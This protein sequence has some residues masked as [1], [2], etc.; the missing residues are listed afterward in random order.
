MYHSHHQNLYSS[1]AAH[2]HYLPIPPPPVPPT[3]SSSTDPGIPPPPPKGCG[4]SSRVSRTAEPR[5]MM[6]DTSSTFQPLPPVSTLTPQN[7]V[8]RAM[9]K[10]R[11]RVAN[12]YQLPPP[13]PPPR[14]LP[15]GGAPSHFNP[16]EILDTAHQ[17]TVNS[18][19]R[20]EYRR[21]PIPL[22]SIPPPPVAP[23]LLPPPPTPP[24]LAP[25]PPPPPLLSAFSEAGPSG[26]SSA[27]SSDDEPPSSST[28]KKRRSVES[29]ARRKTKKEQSRRQREREDEEMALRQDFDD[30][31][32]EEAKM[33]IGPRT[34]SEPYPEERRPSL[35]LSSFP[36]RGPRTPPEPY[37]GGPRTP[38]PDD[39]CEA[40]LN[41]NVNGNGKLTARP[42]S[43]ARTPKT[44]N[45]KPV[46][47]SQSPAT[48]EAARFQSRPLP[49]AFFGM[50]SAQKALKTSVS[51]V[52]EQPAQKVEKVAAPALESSIS[53]PLVT[54]PV[55]APAPV[56]TPTLAPTLPKPVPKLAE[57]ATIKSPAPAAATTNG[58]TL[59][60]GELSLAKRMEAFR[61]RRAAQESANDAPPNDTNAISEK[62]KPSSEVVEPEEA[63]AP[64][65]VPEPAAPQP[66]KEPVEE[67]VEDSKVEGEEEEEEK[68]EKIA[69]VTKAAV[70][71]HPPQQ[72]PAKRGRKR[73]APPPKSPSPSPSATADADATKMP[74]PS[75]CVSTYRTFAEE[76]T[77]GMAMESSSKRRKQL[78]TSS[79]MCDSIEQRLM[80]LN[81][82]MQEIPSRMPD[83]PSPE[84]A[85][86]K[87]ERAIAQSGLISSGRSSSTSSL[88]PS[89]SG[90][91]QA[92]P[93]RALSKSNGNASCSSLDTPNT[94]E[95]S[96]VEIIEETSAKK[97]T[98]T[99]HQYE[100]VASTEPKNT[101]MSEEDIARTDRYI[102][103][104][105]TIRKQREAEAEAA[106]LRSRSGSSVKSTS[107]PF[108]RS[109]DPLKPLSRSEREQ[110]EMVDMEEEEDRKEVVV[111]A[112]VLLQ[113]QQQTKRNFNVTSSASSSSSSAPSRLRAG[114]TVSSII[115]ASP[116]ES[117]KTAMAQL[118]KMPHA[119]ERSSILAKLA[120]R[121][122]ENGAST[123]KLV[124]G[125]IK[126][127]EEEEEDRKARR[128]NRRI[129]PDFEKS[130]RDAERAALNGELY[131]HSI[132]ARNL[133]ELTKLYNLPRI[134]NR[135][136]KFLR[137]RNHPNGGATMLSCDFNRLKNYLKGD[138][139]TMFCRQFVR[140]GFAER[141][142]TPVFCIGV[143]E[144]GAENFGDMFEELVAE[145]ENLQVKVG[146]LV[147][148]Q[149][150][151]TMTIKKYQEKAMETYSHGTFRAGPLMAVSMVG[152]KQEESGLHCKSMLS[153]LESSPFLAPIM[154]WGEFSQLEGMH[155]TDSDDGPIF[156]V[157]PG[158]Q[159]VP[160]DS[161]TNARTARPNPNAIRH[162]ERR[163]IEFLDRTPCHAD[164]VDD[165]E[166]IKR[167]TAAVGILQAVRNRKGDE[168]FPTHPDDRR[169]VKDVVVFHAG[170][171]S[172]VVQNLQ[173]D[174]FEPPTNQCIA[175]VEEGKLNQLA[176]E[177]IRYAK[178]ELRENDMYFL[179]R[180]VVHQFRTIG[181][182]SS[183]AW[184]VR[185]KH[186][187]SK[188]DVAPNS[189]D[190]PEWE[191]DSD[192]S[193]SDEDCE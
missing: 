134:S 70:K 142:G 64:D 14:K 166:T 131:L 89:T 100:R 150:I 26:S 160:T 77:S 104:Q 165:R 66:Q 34:P 91:D 114:S 19:K 96:D 138:D 120:K 117:L 169:A 54:A 189:L 108:H 95:D 71:M 88:Q 25:P 60:A 153:Q 40:R 141:N 62:E 84:T 52:Q 80:E 2:Q 22:S 23:L 35:S 68:S 36:K 94:S 75:R 102:E 110:L 39:D 56:P 98:H 140:L 144:N 24:A 185:L 188:D 162:S 65:P 156:W 191:C 101:I 158:E 175:W 177:G 4:A 115:A 10:S 73:L 12:D 28:I 121:Q 76:D 179:P 190:D 17:T 61:A 59:S 147:S 18:D 182:C 53:A 97:A 42:K 67:K 81:R 5:W 149:L 129:H 43:P 167:S 128:G 85:L 37:P 170:D 50:G 82:K 171:L 69:V 183:I 21:E 164:Q 172:E 133:K 112:H 148:K 99:G 152:A 1:P 124:R 72:I 105:R 123:N 55:P 33:P 127:I 159:T 107:M 83:A 6:G 15:S 7:F 109:I 151:E 86:I 116:H 27:T 173:L 168:D 13:P 157:R 126:H 103:E 74:P 111:A 32:I 143:M 193:D 78:K 106:R 92:P 20:K 174:L 119:E 49:M 44:P 63:P 29:E 180:N 8:G 181:S 161:N 192:D 58:K 57:E 118:K 178:F 87:R 38:P 113:Q 3:S 122:K 163:E 31:G 130:K 139:I 155:P 46:S 184:H 79:D 51:E 137:V 136:R 154:P 135:F 41:G 9:S 125:A 187:Y 176:R 90:Q 16:H 145:N 132:S 47:A 186:Y 93:S 11:E 146:S 30:W 45:A 48:I